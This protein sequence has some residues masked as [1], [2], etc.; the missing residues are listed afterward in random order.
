MNGFER[1]HN[2]MTT[3][4][5]SILHDKGLIDEE[6][7][8]LWLAQILGHMQCLKDFHDDVLQKGFFA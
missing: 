3:K 4:L 5:K 2:E 8:K 1:R 6:T 7:K